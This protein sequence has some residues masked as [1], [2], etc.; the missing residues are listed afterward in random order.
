MTYRL[1][2]LFCGPGGIG[3]GAKLAKV[4]N[5]EIV[6]E[7]AT[8]FDEDTCKTYEKNLVANKKGSVI[9]KDIRELDYSTLNPID[10]LA[11]GFPCNDFSIV[12]EQKGIDGL[13][14]PLYTYAVAALIYPGSVTHGF[15][16]D[17][18]Y[19]ELKILSRGT[20]TITVQTPPNQFVAPA[21][22]Y[23]LV[24]LTPSVC[25]PEEEHDCGPVPSVAKWVRLTQ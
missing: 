23:M 19:I 6:H 11:F 21:G 9:C 18:R 8:D 12:G 15:N 14:G 22:Y 10:A 4:K 13:Y 25:M 1:G 17:Q 24:I 2:E 7:W 5:F 3:L 16:M 20:G